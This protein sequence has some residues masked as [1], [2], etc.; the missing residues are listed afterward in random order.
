VLTNP[1]HEEKQANRQQQM[2]GIGEV[3]DPCCLL[4]LETGVHPRFTS[5]VEDR[6]VAGARQLEP[7]FF[8]FAYASDCRSVLASRRKVGSSCLAPGHLAVLDIGRE[9][10]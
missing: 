10:R 1:I 6:K 5:D 7:T 3:T 8:C 9:A 2:D 4:F